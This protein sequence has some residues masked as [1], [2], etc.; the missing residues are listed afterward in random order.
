MT[1]RGET[2]GFSASDHVRVVED[3]L[4][5]G[6]VQFCIVHSALA[7][8]RLSRDWGEGAAPVACDLGQIRS[9]GVVPIKGDLMIRQGEQI[10]H[11]P[12]R[13]GRMV[14]KIVR[15]RARHGTQPEQLNNPQGVVFQCL[16]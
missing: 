8:A 1:Q 7:G 14:V 3:Y 16:N 15:V 11:D 2:D 12:P 5:R 13:L 9:L 6:V 10:R 4:G